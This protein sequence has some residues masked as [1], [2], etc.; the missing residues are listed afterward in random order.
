VIRQVFALERYDRTHGEAAQ[1]PVP[2]LTTRDTVL[3]GVLRLPADEVVV[4]L[5]EG[6]DAE[7]VAAVAATAG[8]RVDRLSPA[9]WNPGELHVP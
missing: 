7:T 8:W 1:N 9:L 3:L 4:A 6:P 2:P 5:V